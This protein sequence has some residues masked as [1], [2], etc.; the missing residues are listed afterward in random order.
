M[1]D[2]LG[3]AVIT[4]TNQPSAEEVLKELPAAFRSRF[5]FDSQDLS[6]EIES[7]LQSWY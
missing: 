7:K 2:A 4:Y 5:Q 3:F 1:A 6:A